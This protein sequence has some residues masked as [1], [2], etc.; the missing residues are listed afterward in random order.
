MAVSDVERNGVKLKPVHAFIV[1]NMGDGV[2]GNE[3]G[4][5]NGKSKVNPVLKKAI[6]LLKDDTS[7]NLLLYC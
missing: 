6:G 4:L 2:A 1:L 7:G 5:V 3:I